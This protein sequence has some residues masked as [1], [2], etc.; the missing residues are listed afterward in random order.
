MAILNRHKSS[1]TTAA[2]RLGFFNQ[3]IG[4]GHPYRKLRRTAALG[5]M[6]SE[7][8]ERP[9]VYPAIARRVAN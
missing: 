6:R 4:E 9:A 1:N 2:L 3:A 8:R 7:L 5:R